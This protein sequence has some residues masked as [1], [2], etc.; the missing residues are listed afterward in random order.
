MG[1]HGQFPPEGPARSG[2]KLKRLMS[3]VHPSR[4]LI[5]GYAG[6]LNPS[7]KVGDLVVAGRVSL[8]GEKPRVS[9][10][11]ENLELSGSWELAE[12]QEILQLVKTAGAQ[13][14]G[15]DLLTSPYI[16]GEPRQKESLFRRFN[17]DAI[18]META[19]LARIAVPAGIPVSCV[20]SISDEAQDEFLAPFS[21]DPHSGPIGR[22]AKVVTAGN[23]IR[24]CRD[25]RERAAVARASL[26]KFLEVYLGSRPQT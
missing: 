11:L 22:A 18:D 12:G 23:W 17:A 14:I 24:R 10:P 4:I 20:R 25:W 3:D 16:I 7:L 1:D 2:A 9:T 13:M 8:I 15:G 5:V 19:A 6:A 26:R 21:Y